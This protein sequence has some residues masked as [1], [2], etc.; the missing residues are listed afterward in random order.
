ML[1]SL[2]MPPCCASLCCVQDAPTFDEYLEIY[3]SPV[4]VD[5]DSEQ[6]WPLPAPLRY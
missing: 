3:D 1:P 4:N 6:V 2:T 5:L